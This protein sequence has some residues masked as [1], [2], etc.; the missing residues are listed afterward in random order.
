MV[1]NI[2]AKG[3]VSSDGHVNRNFKVTVK[4]NC[5]PRGSK[6]TILRIAHDGG[7]VVLIDLRFACDKRDHKYFLPPNA[8]KGLDVA[9]HGYIDSSTVMIESTDPLS[10]YR[11]ELTLVKPFPML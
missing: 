6:G 2:N 9:W 10:C 11:I 8:I 3:C 5:W 7:E 4:A 1:R